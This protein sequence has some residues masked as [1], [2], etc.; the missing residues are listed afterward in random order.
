MDPLCDEVGHDRSPASDRDTVKRYRP[1]ETGV[2]V[3]FYLLA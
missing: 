3:D 1:A 2:A